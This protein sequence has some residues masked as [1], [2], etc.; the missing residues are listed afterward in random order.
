MPALNP[1]LALP[2][3]GAADDVFDRLEGA[4]ALARS[5]EGKASMSGTAAFIRQPSGL[6]KYR[7]EGRIRLEDGK[8]FDGHREYFYER[9]PGGFTVLFAETP[10][11]VFHGI[12]I[13]REGD[14]L[15]GA[16]NHLCI[17]DNYD[18]RYAFHADGSFVVEHTV[19]G[20]RKDYLSRTVFT[21]RTG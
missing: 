16:A 5:I 13:V 14:A 4:W 18:S 3:W 17:A 20:P 15:I 21:R 1:D 11:R 12:A 2:S 10:M 8:E 19:K 7:E 6:L 9:S